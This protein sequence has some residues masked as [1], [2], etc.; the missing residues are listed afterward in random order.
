MVPPAGLRRST[1]RERTGRT[2]SRSGGST[3]RSR[4]DTGAGASSSL[5][6]KTLFKDK[7]SPQ[8]ERKKMIEDLPYTER[9]KRMREDQAKLENQN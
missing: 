8:S 2:G 9:E 6:R 7:N 4:R 1:T 5:P 3:P